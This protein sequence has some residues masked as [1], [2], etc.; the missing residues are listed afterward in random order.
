MYED[1]E[2][3]MTPFDDDLIASQEIAENLWKQDW[4]LV[5]ITEYLNNKYPYY[6]YIIGNNIRV[7]DGDDVVYDVFVVSY[8]D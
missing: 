7:A 1:P 6:F 8:E 3:E 4:T 2:V 5:E